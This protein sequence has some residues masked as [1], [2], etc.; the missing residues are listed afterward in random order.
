MTS[1]TSGFDNIFVELR[2]N[3]RVWESE[4]NFPRLSSA[5][6]L[7]L[8]L[9]ADGALAR[10]NRQPTTWDTGVRRI[11][12]WSD[13]QRLT[14]KLDSSLSFSRKYCYFWR[15]IQSQSFFMP[16]ELVCCISSKVGRSWPTTS[17]L[18]NITS[19]NHSNDASFPDDSTV[20]SLGNRMQRIFS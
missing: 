19:T 4:R 5:T 18:R 20:L 13:S 17:I 15:W 10:P 7:H 3:Y 9:N 8:R 16:M 14:L 12:R 11:Q 2:V 6:T 1:W